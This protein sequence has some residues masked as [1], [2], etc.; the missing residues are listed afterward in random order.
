MQLI[1]LGAAALNQTPL[2]WDGNVARI[3]LACE[4]ARR[5]QIA[6]LCCPELCITG[7][8]CEDAFHSSG[9]LAAAM[10]LVVMGAQATTVS[11]VFGSAV[12]V[13]AIA[14][15]I[16]G[17][18]ADSEGTESAFLFAALLVLSTSLLAF[19]TRW[20]VKD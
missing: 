3:T 8:G 19:I 18:I 6:I 16:A 7:Y 10:D 14:P 20:E 13:S 17:I 15:A 9:V 2:D 12:V 11:L 1:R 4:E 5:R